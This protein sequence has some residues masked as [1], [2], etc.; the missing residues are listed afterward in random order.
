M[1]LLKIGGSV[2]TDKTKPYTALEDKIDAIARAIRS[3]YLSGKRFVIGHGGGS[4]PHVSAKRF[5]VHKG[6]RG[7][8]S[9]FGFGVVHY[10]ATWINQIFMRHLHRYRVP[11]ISFH[12]NSLFL[13][14]DG[15][16]FKEFLDP[17]FEA[18]RRRI[19]PVV[20]GDAVVDVS[21]GSTIFSTEVILRAIAERER[22]DVVIG[23]AEKFG[24]VYTDDP[25]KNP[26]AELIREVNRRNYE[27]VLSH[28]GGSHGVD[29]TGGMR[30]KVIELLELAKEGIPSVI[31]KGTP[32]NVEAFLKGKEVEG[33]YFTW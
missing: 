29:V 18:L 23:M 7:S 20:Y 15:K 22:N 33:T 1:R 17:V 30:H 26:D 11:S 4:F 3:A 2:I 28:V 32:E 8:S 12:P 25:A 24:G 19:V 13:G 31:F 10:D 16:P 27:E 9:R 14:K 5:A 21:K 6:I